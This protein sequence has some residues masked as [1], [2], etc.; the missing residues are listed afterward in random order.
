SLSEF[1]GS[2]V[3]VSFSR[4]GSLGDAPDG[5]RRQFQELLKHLLCVFDL[6]V[7]CPAPVAPYPCGQAP[8]MREWSKGFTG[9]DDISMS[10]DVIDVVLPTLVKERSLVE[11]GAV[12]LLPR[13][14]R[15]ED[16]A[17]LALPQLPRPFTEG[18]DRS[19]EASAT[20]A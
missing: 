18:Q 15:W 4:S 19:A 13:P 9:T 7:I 14:E 16:H 20:E 2:K 10:N 3:F 1:R 5:E 8:D 6:M 12:T 11:T 17:F